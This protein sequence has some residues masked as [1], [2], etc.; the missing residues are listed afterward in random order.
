[1]ATMIYTSAALSQNRFETYGNG[2]QQLE[3]LPHLAIGLTPIASRLRFYLAADW[4]RATPSC[5]VEVAFF[6][7]A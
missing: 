5:P 1:M 3:R 6:T 2:F 7:S 4:T